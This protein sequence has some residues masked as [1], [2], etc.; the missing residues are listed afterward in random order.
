MRF[1]ATCTPSVAS[2]TF[3]CGVPAEQVDQHALVMGVQVL[4]QHERHAGIRGHIGEERREGFEAAGG[5]ADT[6]DQPRRFCLS[7]GMRDFVSA[8]FALS[9]PRLVRRFV[10]RD[11]LSVM[12]CFRMFVNVCRGGSDGRNFPGGPFR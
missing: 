7:A 12:A 3:I 9:L 11:F 6:D 2:I 1:A 10:P 8:D 5:G 4:H